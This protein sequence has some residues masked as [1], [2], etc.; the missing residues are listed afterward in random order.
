M[1]TLRIVFGAF[2]TALGLYYCICGALA[3][4]VVHS[5]GTAA[6]SHPLLGSFAIILPLGFIV[7]ASGIGLLL[8]CRW[9]RTL[10][11][12]T[13]PL[14]VAFHVLWLVYGFTTDPAIARPPAVLIVLFCIA[15]SA[16]LLFFATHAVDERRQVI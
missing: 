11:L 10:W 4:I 8:H 14:V 9:A 16:F 2:I 1:T 5:I 15:S 6:F 7:A 13:S 3:A 12:V